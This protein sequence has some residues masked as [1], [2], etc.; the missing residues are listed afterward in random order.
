M[1]KFCFLK[2]K[3]KETEKEF[4]AEGF[5]IEKF[6]CI[7]INYSFSVVFL[8]SSLNPDKFGLVFVFLFFKNKGMKAVQAKMSQM[9][10]GEGYFLLILLSR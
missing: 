3:K 10:K 2:K 8:F 9:G 1:K 4:K 7:G 5:L 6:N